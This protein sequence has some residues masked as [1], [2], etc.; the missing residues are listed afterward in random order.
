[1]GL[2]VTS[3]TPEARD[4]A[5]HSV[6]VRF[7][8]DSS[9]LAGICSSMADYACRGR[10]KNAHE[11]MVVLR[12]LLTN[13][14]EHGNKHDPCKPVICRVTRLGAHAAEIAVEDEGDGFDP[15]QVDL[16]CPASP[17]DLSRNGLRIANALSSALWFEEGGRRT[18]CR[19]SWG[20][21]GR[22]ST[23]AAPAPASNAE[24]KEGLSN[25]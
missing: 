24:T 19:L 25:A 5:P 23:I 13:A 9:L 3:M 7:S 16:G 20:P 10:Q 11:L 6:E 1:M 14:V 4:T 15:A 21:E 22:L 2:R 12:E 17:A 8:S 18:V